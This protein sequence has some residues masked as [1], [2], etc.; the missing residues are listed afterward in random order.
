MNLHEYQGKSILKQYGVA[1]P[2]GIVAETPNQ[3]VDA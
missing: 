1:V 2:E 3:A